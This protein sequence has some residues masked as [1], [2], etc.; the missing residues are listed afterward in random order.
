M[1][2]VRSAHLKNLSDH[3]VQIICI[4]YEHLN[5]VVGDLWAA[6]AAA[7]ALVG[8]AGRATERDL[9]RTRR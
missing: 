8:G 9:A 2:G 6:A 1:L 7:P 5:A 4:F 3:I